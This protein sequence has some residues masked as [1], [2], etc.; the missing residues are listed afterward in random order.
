MS[1]MVEEKLSVHNCGEME[2]TE[3]RNSAT[4]TCPP[5]EEVACPIQAK[6]LKKRQAT[7]KGRRRIKGRMEKSITK[8]KRMQSK[9]VITR[10][11]C[12]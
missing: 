2:V 8:K 12:I 6:G 11:S 7:S 1:V 5:S 9:Q 3:L 4:N 10:K